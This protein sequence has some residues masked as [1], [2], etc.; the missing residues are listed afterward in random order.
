MSSSIRKLSPEFYSVLITQGLN[1]F[2]VMHL[3]DAVLTELGLKE[4]CDVREQHKRAYRVVLRLIASGFLVKEQAD[5]GFACYRRTSKFLDCQ[6]APRGADNVT[7]VT[8]FA[9]LA[10]SPN[11]SDDDSEKSK[12]KKSLEALVKGYQVDLLSAIGETEEYMRLHETY[13]QLKQKLERH[14]LKSREKSSKILGQIKA[15]ECLLAELPA[16]CLP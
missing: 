1:N 12:V 5:S 3:R 16:D 15:V 4:A 2:T 6:F 9:S 7:P 8:K 10:L 14:Y 13:P 11:Q